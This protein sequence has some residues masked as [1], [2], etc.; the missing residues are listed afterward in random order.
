MRL[1]LALGILA[2]ALSANAQERYSPPYTKANLN[3]V[4]VSI[5]D[6]A[7]EGCWTNISEVKSYAEGQLG[8][9]DFDVD[10]IENAR[11]VLNLTVQSQRLDSGV[12]FGGIKGSLLGWVTF[13]R[14]RA[15]VVLVDFEMVTFTGYENANTQTL[16]YVK[17]IISNGLG[18]IPAD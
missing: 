14:E 10:E 13:A 11:T 18:S 3:P 12:C 17:S 1:L 6:D 9:A 7:T 2:C 5:G 15:F 16:D 8:L 4:A